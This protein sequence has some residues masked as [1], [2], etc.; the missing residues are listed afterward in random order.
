MSLVKQR[1]KWGYEYHFGKEP[2]FSAF[3]DYKKN[4][5]SE[6]FRL[7]SSIEEFFEYVISLEEKL[8]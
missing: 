6:L 2:W 8:K 7:N 1:I 5:D 4:R 3:L